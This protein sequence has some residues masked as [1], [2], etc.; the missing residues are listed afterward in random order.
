MCN[1]HC[2]HYSGTKVH[3]M[4]NLAEM[5]HVWPLV[6]IME[7][8]STPYVGMPLQ[9]TASPLNVYEM[10]CSEIVHIVPYLI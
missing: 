3:I 8:G 10:T 9:K 5:Q 2:G 7:Y 1:V 4:P 6:T